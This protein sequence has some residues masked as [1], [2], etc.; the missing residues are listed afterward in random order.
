[1]YLDSVLGG[2]LTVTSTV[3]ADNSISVVSGGITLT[4]YNHISPSSSSDIGNTVVPGAIVF[5]LVISCP[6][7]LPTANAAPSTNT[8]ISKVL[9]K[10]SNESFKF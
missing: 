10:S 6:T 1:M 5:T 4:I 7:T 9:T 3:E 8:F 2:G